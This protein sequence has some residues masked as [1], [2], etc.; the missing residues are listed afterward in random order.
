MTIRK[1]QFLKKENAKGFL[2]IFSQSYVKNDLRKTK[3]VVV[4]T[5]GFFE[6]SAPNL[7]H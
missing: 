2:L 3:I 6:V 1:I 7:R 5:T 4:F